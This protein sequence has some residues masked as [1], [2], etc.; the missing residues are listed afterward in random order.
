MLS[1]HRLGRIHWKSLLI[2]GGLLVAGCLQ[3]PMLPS[4]QPPDRDGDRDVGLPLVHLANG[5][6][7]DPDDY[8]GVPAVFRQKFVADR[9]ANEPTIGIGPD[10]TLFFRVSA[11]TGET[12]GPKVLRSRDQG[13]T[14]H[15]VTP[16]LVAGLV[17]VPPFTADAF[18]HVDPQTGRVF[19]YHQQT[20]VVCGYWSISSDAGENWWSRDTCQD[21]SYGDH[22]SIT[23]GKP[24]TVQPPAGE[25]VA[26]FCATIGPASCRTSL[27][28]GQSFGP[29]VTALEPCQDRYGQRG[30]P[31]MGHVKMAPDGTAYVGNLACHLARIG[32]SRDDGR[33]WKTVIVDNTSW[34][35]ERPNAALDHEANVAIDAAGIVYYAFIGSDDLPRLSVSLDGGETWRPPILIAPPA[36]TA[37]NFPTIVAGDRGRIAYFYVGTTVEGGFDASSSAMAEAAWNGYITFSLNADDAE[38]VFLTTL[39][40]AEKDPLRRGDC[41]G[42]CTIRRGPL[43]ERDP[44][45]GGFLQGG[46]YDFLD[47]DIDPTT[48]RVFVALADV[49]TGPCADRSGAPDSGQVRSAVGVQVAGT[50]LLQRY[51]Q[52]ALP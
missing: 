50:G 35:E 8:P 12:P 15:D 3:T 48:G 52:V 36:V 24:R 38:P 4:A 1:G 33:A 2:G 29:P 32:I 9:T 22:P 10:G 47:M 20:F 14:W 18:L 19:S 30:A 23:T 28:G 45:G 6:I 17:D 5:I 13:E 25:N 16:K 42:R 49:C 44:I 46:I 39:V 37:T 34:P 40:H 21:S 31:W 43:G 7:L 26:Y 11:S 51:D 41:S 27:D